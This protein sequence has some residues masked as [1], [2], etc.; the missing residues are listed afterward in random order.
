[1]MQTREICGVE[2]AV[3]PD[4]AEVLVDIGGERMTLAEIE[5]LR[6]AADWSRTVEI[7]PY[8]LDETSLATLKSF[9]RAAAER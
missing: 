6:P 2:V 3:D 7:G 5:K 1:M 8:T 4:G 9:V